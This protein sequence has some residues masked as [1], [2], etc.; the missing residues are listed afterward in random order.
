MD[1]S[2]KRGLRK[3]D[4]REGHWKCLMD[5]VKRRLIGSI[6][7]SDISFPLVSMMNAIMNGKVYD[8]ASLLATRMEEFMTLQHKTFYMPHYAIRLFLEATA[9]TI[10][11][12]Q[13]EIKPSSAV[14]GEPPV[15]QWRHLDSPIGQ[16][17]MGQKRAQQEMEESGN[18]DSG[19]QDTSCEEDDS[20]GMEVEQDE[21][22]DDEEGR[23]ISAVPLRFPQHLM[24]A[25]VT[26]TSVPAC[27][28][29]HIHTM[30]DVYIPKFD[31][32]GVQ[33]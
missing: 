30:A 16:K 31:S 19:R 8:W 9:R 27:P 10:P 3:S 29:P 17:G 6:K 4:I 26:T 15:M 22:E 12:E 18:T 14:P 28:A 5:V 11:H 33:W 32:F 2:K 7:A 23:V 24:A 13:L 1:T 20:E 25:P 21:E